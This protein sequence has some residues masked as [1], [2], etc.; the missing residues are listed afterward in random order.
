MSGVFAVFALLVFIVFLAP[1]VL[2]LMHV[3]IW[4]KA[5]SSGCP[6]SLAQIIFMRVRDN[7][8]RLLIDVYLTLRKSGVDV[9][10]DDVEAAYMVNKYELRGIGDKTR[11]ARELVQLVEAAQAA[12]P[13]PAAG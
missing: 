5:V 3:V 4:M 12:E 2:I 6:V 7:P 8:P 9:S 10:V 13:G 1:W 11:R